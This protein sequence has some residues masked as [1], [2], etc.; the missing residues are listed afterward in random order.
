MKIVNSRPSGFYSLF[1]VTVRDSRNR[2]FYEK[3]PKSGEKL[4]FNLPKGE[5]HILT[6]QIS[7]RRFVD[8]QSKIKLP[9]KERNLKGVYSVLHEEI[10]G[11]GFIDH[12]K[13]IIVLNNDLLPFKALQ[14][15]VLQHEIGHT[16][17]N[18]EWKCDI[19]A[20][21]AMLAKG[22]NPSQIV[23]ASDELKRSPERIEYVFNQ[24][25]NNFS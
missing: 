6:P 2:L 24:F 19:Y 17:Y 3:S 10:E 9:P 5:F 16:L 8:F 13:K 7:S 25:L 22:Y 21:K 14:E 4:V 20:A 1:P 15:F 18:T 12:D 11:N 23:D